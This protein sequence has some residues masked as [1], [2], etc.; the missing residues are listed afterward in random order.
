MKIFAK[1]QVYGDELLEILCKK[2]SLMSS[3]GLIK[4][5]Q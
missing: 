4:I 5:Y 1:L 3:I 2:V